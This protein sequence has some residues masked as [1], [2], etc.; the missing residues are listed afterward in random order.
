MASVPSLSSSRGGVDFKAL[1]RPDGGVSVQGAKEVTTS[2]SIIGLRTLGTTIGRHVTPS[3]DD[4][5]FSGR[6]AMSLE[7][8]KGVPASMSTSRSSTMRA[9]RVSGLP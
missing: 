1:T 6:T 2:D 7:V 4:L 9:F 5:T 8:M 3:D